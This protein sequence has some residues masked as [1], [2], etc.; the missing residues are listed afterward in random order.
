MDDSSFIPIIWIYFYIK[1]KALFQ[2]SSSLTKSVYKIQM[3]DAF[4][5]CEPWASKGVEGLA[6]KPANR[7]LVCGI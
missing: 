6:A 4:K 7:S 2:D 3:K 5:K 1:K